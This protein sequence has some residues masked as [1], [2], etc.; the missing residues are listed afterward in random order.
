M[1]IVAK[2]GVSYLT[3]IETILR[4][5]YLGGSPQGL[6]QHG[7]LA[8][9]CYMAFPWQ[10]AKRKAV[11]GY[12]SHDDSSDNSECSSPFKYAYGVNA[13]KHWVRARRPDGD[14]P[15]PPDA[16]RSRKGPAPLPAPRPAPR[17]RL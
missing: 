17:P 13:W 16:R 10:G 15:P 4:V 8:R 2:K 11:S 5:A 1:D 9:G 3:R 14:L 6:E 12:Q 7:P